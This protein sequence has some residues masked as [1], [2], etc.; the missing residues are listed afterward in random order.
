MRHK[1]STHAFVLGRV[2]AREAGLLVVLLTPEFGLI[3]AR[4]E[5]LRRPGAKLAHALQTFC[6]SDITL[7]RGRDGWRVTGAL[8]T[9]NWFIRLSPSAA[10]RAGRIA[11]LM[12][13]LVHGEVNE[14]ELFTLFSS[15]MAA[16]PELSEEVQDAHECVV[17]LRVLAALGLDAG[18]LP[19]TPVQALIPNMRRDLV[20]RINAGI[21]ASGL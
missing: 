4:A 16:L 1:Y 6:E 21:A 3:R 5:G 14:P 12:L 10:E 9:E 20:R 17:A 7:V 13:R 2:P 19:E 15:F 11:G 18:D 8:L